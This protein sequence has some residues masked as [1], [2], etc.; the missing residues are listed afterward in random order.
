MKSAYWNKPFDRQFGEERANLA[1]N[2]GNSPVLGLFRPLKGTLEGEVRQF[3][4]A[5]RLF[6]T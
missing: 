1:G 2:G 4:P 5:P 6:C 3:A